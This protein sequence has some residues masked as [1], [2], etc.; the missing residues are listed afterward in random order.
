MRTSVQHRAVALL[1]LMNLAGGAAFL[2]FISLGV[3]SV[4]FSPDQRSV[5]HIGSGTFL[6]LWTLVAARV[7]GGAGWVSSVVRRV[8]LP[9]LPMLMAAPVAVWLGPW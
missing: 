9:A 2:A 8:S 7:M 6:L 4:E 3:M 1:D 5:A